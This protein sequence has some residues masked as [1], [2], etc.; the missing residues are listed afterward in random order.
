MIS[1]PAINGGIFTSRLVC[2][3]LIMNPLRQSMTLRTTSSIDHLLSLL[4]FCCGCVP[5][6]KVVDAVAVSMSGGFGVSQLWT[7]RC[8]LYCK[9]LHIVDSKT[10][11]QSHDEIDILHAMLVYIDIL[12]RAMPK[13]GLCTCGCSCSLQT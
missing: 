12:H 5:V 1:K 4:L 8:L 3:C 13:N 10:A 9:T 6:M 2:Q 7:C 11:W